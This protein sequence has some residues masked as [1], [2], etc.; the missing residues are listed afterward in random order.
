MMKPSLLPLLLTAVL[1]SVLA[2]LCSGLV[3]QFWLSYGTSIALVP[4]AAALG[5]LDLLVAGAWLGY[6]LERRRQTVSADHV[7]SQP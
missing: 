4:Q 6:F 1:S 3:A 2:L 5:L 7:L